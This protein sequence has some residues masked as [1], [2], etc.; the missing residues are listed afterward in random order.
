MLFIHYITHLKTKKYLVLL[1]GESQNLSKVMNINKGKVK[2]NFIIQP[3]ITQWS[4]TELLLQI[5]SFYVLF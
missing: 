1:N 5:A 3:F 2:M 4:K